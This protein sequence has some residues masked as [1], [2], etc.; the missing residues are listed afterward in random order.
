MKLRS[1]SEYAIR[2]GWADV[3]LAIGIGMLGLAGGVLA[4]L[5]TAPANTHLKLGWVEPASIAVACAGFL[6]SG[7]GGTL[8]V[9]SG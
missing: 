5:L 9:K 1:Q 3:L 8:K 4:V 7:I 2:E 6:L